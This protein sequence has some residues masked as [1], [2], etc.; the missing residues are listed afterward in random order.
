VP[1]TIRGVGKKS[2]QIPLGMEA[3]KSY[4]SDVP[5]F[6]KKIDMV[7]TVRELGRPGAYLVVHKAF[8]VFTFQ[9]TSAYAIQVEHTET[10]MSFTPLDFEVSQLKSS[11]PVVKGFVEG[12]LVLKA[13]DDN[14]V[15]TDLTF[16]HTADVEQTGPIAFVPAPMLKATA[17]NITSMIIGST[18]ESMWRK[19]Q[20]DFPNSKD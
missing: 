16:V 14:S 19:V 13:I 11:I 20:A 12:G 7:E 4:F 8:G 15:A 5:S 1:I 9:A 18:I 10:G 6:L 3:A 17:D 2:A